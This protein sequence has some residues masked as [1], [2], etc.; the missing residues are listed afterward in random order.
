VKDSGSKFLLVRIDML[1]VRIIAAGVKYYYCKG[2]ILI[3]I[4][5]HKSKT[6]SV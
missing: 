6:K 4:F 2:S 5:F 3:I 1:H